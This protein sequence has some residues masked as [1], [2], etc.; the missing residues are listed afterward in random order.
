MIGKPRV[1]VAVIAR[2]LRGSFVH[3][4]EGDGDPALNGVSRLGLRRLR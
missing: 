2:R 3:N 1:A 4:D